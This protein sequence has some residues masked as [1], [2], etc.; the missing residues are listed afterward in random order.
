MCREGT[1]YVGRAGRDRRG[2]GGGRMSFRP[3]QRVR[4]GLRTTDGHTRL[5]DYARGRIGTIFRNRGSYPIPD[6]LVRSGHAS[7]Q[8]LYS[9][10]FH[11]SD[12]WGEDA[13]AHDVYLDLYESYLRPVAE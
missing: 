1:D 8:P 5:P 11:A 10:R 6:E 12:L 7:D 3:G 13:G 9:V 4:T 2:S